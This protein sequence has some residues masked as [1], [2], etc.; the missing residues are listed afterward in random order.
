MDCS[1]RVSW[2]Q[3]PP[4]LPDTFGHGHYC[5]EGSQLERY[6]SR[7]L[8]AAPPESYDGNEF[9]L[10]YYFDLAFVCKTKFFARFALPTSREPD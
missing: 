2:F 5:V 1:G 9:F 10:C 6:D 7:M 4:Q 8:P 3:L